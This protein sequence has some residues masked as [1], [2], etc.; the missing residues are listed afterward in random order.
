MNLIIA[1]PHLLLAQCSQTSRMLGEVT[2]ATCTTAH[3]SAAAAV[4]LEAV[5]VAGSK[6]KIAWHVNIYTLKRRLE[7]RHERIDDRQERLC[8]GWTTVLICL[9]RISIHLPDCCINRQQKELQDYKLAH[10]AIGV[11]TPV[12][13]PRILLR[14]SV[15]GIRNKQS[16]RNLFIK[17]ISIEPISY[18]KAE[19]GRPDFKIASTTR[20]ITGVVQTKF[21]SHKQSKEKNPAFPG[22]AEESRTLTR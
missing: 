4:P 18:D 22:I 20:L 13:S 17:E 9:H 3:M 15:A 16:R 21:T 1:E 2:R 19:K 12:L 5:A 14:A 8:R 11:R 10:D 6:L 7:F